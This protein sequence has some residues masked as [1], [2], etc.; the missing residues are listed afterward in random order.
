MHFCHV[1]NYFSLFFPQIDNFSFTFWRQKHFWGKNEK[2]M[3]EKFSLLLIKKSKTLKIFHSEKRKN[4]KKKI[5]R[6]FLELVNFPHQFSSCCFCFLSIFCSQFWAW[7]SNAA[8]KGEEEEE[9][10]KNSYESQL[11]THNMRNFF[12]FI[13]F[14]THKPRLS[15]AFYFYFSLLRFQL[16]TSA[17]CRVPACMWRTDSTQKFIKH[18]LLLLISFL[19]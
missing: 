7:D 6:D 1:E 4:K 3:W 9:M 10:A 11:A 5:S 13:L 15:L 12:P 2:F 14:S 16:P 8:A 18:I 17:A 19:I